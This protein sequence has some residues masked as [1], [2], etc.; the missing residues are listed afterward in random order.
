MKYL[1]KFLQDLSELCEPL[2]HLTHIRKLSDTGLTNR[3]MALR[4]LKMLSP[5]HQY[6]STSVRV[7]QT[8]AKEMHLE[9]DLALY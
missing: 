4:K 8:K 1:S 7:T 6:S 5:K 3:K 2:C 9:M